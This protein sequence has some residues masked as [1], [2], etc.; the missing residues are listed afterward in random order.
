MIRHSTV[1]GAVVTGDY[2]WETRRFRLH[3]RAAAGAAAADPARHGCGHGGDGRL[4][5]GGEE[6]A[7]RHI[8]SPLLAPCA[9]IRLRW[10]ISGADACG[11]MADPARI[12][13]W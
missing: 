10:G 12:L 6:A 4:Q 13:H 9:W 7:R 8:R 3:R 1:A 11:S 2:G 5:A